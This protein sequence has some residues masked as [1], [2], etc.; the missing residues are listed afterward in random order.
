M[1]KNTFMCVVIDLS[2]RRGFTEYINSL[3]Y[4]HPVIDINITHK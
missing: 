3:Q 4:F 1:I 2:E